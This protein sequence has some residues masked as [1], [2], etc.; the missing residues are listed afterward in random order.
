MSAIAVSQETRSN[1]P[2]ARRAAA[3]QVTRSGSFWTSVI[4]MPLGH[5]S[6]GRQRMVLVGPQLR[7]DAVLDRGDHAAVRLADAADGDLCS[8]AISAP[9]CSAR[10]PASRRRV[11]GRQ[12]SL[13]GRYRSSS[14]R[15]TPPGSRPS[16]ASL[17]R[18]AAS[19]TAAAGRS[20]AGASDQT[21][22]SSSSGR[23]GR[24]R[25]RREP[26]LA[27]QAVVAVL[28]ELRPRLG[29]ERAVPRADQRRGRA[30]AA[31]SSA[32]R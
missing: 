28:L 8:T 11:T 12:E 14:G 21:R 3:D 30:R 27:V 13:R 6:P 5:A 10:R 1:S 25:A 23:A 18:C 24:R 15:S 31:G 26:P 20:A 9:R 7:D 4:A 29:D 19:V 32:A 17:S 2:S 22:S 16:S